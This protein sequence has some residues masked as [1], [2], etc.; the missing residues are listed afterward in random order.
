MQTEKESKLRDL[1]SSTQNRQ[2]ENRTRQDFI[3]LDREQGEEKD[4]QHQHQLRA[5][6]IEPKKG[7]SYGKGSLINV[8]R[9]IESVQDTEKGGEAV[10]VALDLIP[11]YLQNVHCVSYKRILH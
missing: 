1:L 9:K 11:E 7:F 6:D 8:H 3:S 4:T 2:Q 10:K 5:A